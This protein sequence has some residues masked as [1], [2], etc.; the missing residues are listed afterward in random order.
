M[1]HVADLD[2]PLQQHNA[3]TYGISGNSILNNSRY[4]HVVVG[5][6]PDI[7]HDILEGTAQLTLKCLIHHLIYDRKLF[8]FSTHN[9]RISSFQYG[10]A[11]QKNKPS[12][13]S[14]A[15]FRLS[16]TLKQ[17]GILLYAHVTHVLHIPFNSLTSIVPC[18][19]LPSAGW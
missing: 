14:Q 5:L 9:E 11:E 12:I 17:S 10:F 16:D 13:I 8:S 4:F 2:G 18:S 1:S 19:L 7:M 15:S 6:A 3:T